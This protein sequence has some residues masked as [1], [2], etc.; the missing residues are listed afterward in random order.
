M[1]NS[2]NAEK[3]TSLSVI[4]CKDFF[5]KCCDLNLADFRKIYIFCNF[6]LVQEIEK[7]DFQMRA[8]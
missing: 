3:K 2:Q 7:S 5:Q 1:I 4:I 8:Q 6:T